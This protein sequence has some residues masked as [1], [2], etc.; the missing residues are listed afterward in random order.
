[1][2]RVTIRAPME[3]DIMKNRRL[4]SVLVITYLNDTLQKNEIALN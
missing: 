3:F 4:F 2:A 1:M